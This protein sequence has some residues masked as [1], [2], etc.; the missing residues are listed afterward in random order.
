MCI[1]D[2]PSTYVGGELFNTE[3]PGATMMALPSVAA[4]WRRQGIDGAAGQRVVLYCGS[5][6]RSAYA[7]LMGRLMGWRNVAS[8][9]GGE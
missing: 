8:Y 2:G 4:Q 7:W 1:G 9:D 5:G 3:Q 6:W